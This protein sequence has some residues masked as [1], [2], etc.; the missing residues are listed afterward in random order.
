MSCAII[1]IT[2]SNILLPLISYLN[3][4]HEKNVT[5]LRSRQEKVRISTNI[6]VDP[7]PSGLPP[8]SK[9]NTIT[10]LDYK[11]FLKPVE[12]VAEPEQGV[13]VRVLDDCIKN[14]FIGM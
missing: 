5:Y 1:L 2:M 9:Q 7:F 6:I 12:L 8:F 3:D 13:G 11:H 10:D 4:A 14:A